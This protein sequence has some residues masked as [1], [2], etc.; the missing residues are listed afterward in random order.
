MRIAIVSDVHGNETA[1]E[2]I[3]TDLRATSPDLILH[4][5]DLA[6][7]G[8]SPA[9]VV[10]QIRDLGWPGVMGNADEIY[11]R[12]ESLNEFARQSSA[13]QSLWSA[14][15]ERAAATRA[16]LGEDRISWMRSFPRIQV[17]DSFALVHASPESVWRSPGY[18]ASDPE[19]EKTY[20]SL[21]KELVVFGHI[22]RPFVRI[23]HAGNGQLIIANAGSAGLPYDADPR[24]AYLL[25]DN[26]SATIRRV[27]YE[28][29]K[30]IRALSVCP[31]P[32]S[33]WIARMLSS[34][35][36]QLP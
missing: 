19:L 3:L 18:E 24:A 1:F 34:G 32:H 4:G 17:H 16:I 21:G 6:D 7:G 31:L 2:A 25:I 10:D 29:D 33:D 22:H 8:S 28:V 20:A 5:G 23:V 35:T 15:R 12:P 13:P 36:P 30:E 9:V 26:G 27:E 11:T 14:V